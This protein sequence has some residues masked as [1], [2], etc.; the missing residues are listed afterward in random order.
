MTAL[1]TGEQPRTMGADKG[2]DTRGFLA[3]PPMGSKAPIAR[4]DQPLTNPLHPI[5]PADHLSCP[6]AANADDT[7]PQG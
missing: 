3:S 4:E 5:P 2:Y 6:H 7:L 1:L